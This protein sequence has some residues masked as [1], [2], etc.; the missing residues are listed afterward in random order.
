MAI[1]KEQPIPH[2]HHQRTSHSFSHETL[3]Q[4]SYHKE[5][6]FSIGAEFLIG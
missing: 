3:M 2:Q 1:R 4:L 5:G 6:F